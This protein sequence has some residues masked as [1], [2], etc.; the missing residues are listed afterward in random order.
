VHYGQDTR[1]AARL[2][3]QAE[4]EA[5]AAVEA[6][7]DDAVEPVPDPAADEP[8]ASDSA[9]VR[10]IA[11]DDPL[12]ASATREPMQTIIEAITAPEALANDEPVETPKSLAQTYAEAGVRGERMGYVWL[13]AVGGLILIRLLIDP[14]M[15]RRPLLEPNLSPGGLTFI[16]ISLFVFLMANVIVNEP[17]EDIG[18]RP[19][20]A[21]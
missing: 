11:P 9:S 17:T 2:L 3:S 21:P 16:G 18:R 10:P 13:F 7:A 6:A 14:T 15:V 1:K 12:P 19:R 8:A 20:N 5:A 4:A